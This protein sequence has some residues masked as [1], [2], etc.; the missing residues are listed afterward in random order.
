VRE[1]SGLKAL[2]LGEGQLASTSFIII[3]PIFAFVNKTVKSMVIAN[4]I[5]DVVFKRLMQTTAE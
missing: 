3:F 5:Y 4:P 1:K 2:K